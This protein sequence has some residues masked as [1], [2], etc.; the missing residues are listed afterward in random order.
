MSDSW[1]QSE[2]FLGGIQ[3][4][5]RGGAARAP[6]QAQQRPH[7]ARHH[8]ADA[9]RHGEQHRLAQGHRCRVC[10]QGVLTVHN[11]I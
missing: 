4:N 5:Y 1:I 6:R 3:I 7:R 10:C 8:R 2:H 9:P 11:F